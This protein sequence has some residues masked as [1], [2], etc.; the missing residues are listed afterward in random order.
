MLRTS[1]RALGSKILFLED[2]ETKRATGSSLESPTHYA[3]ET[4]NV[5]PDAR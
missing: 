4:V 5:N 3:E 1:D 2:P